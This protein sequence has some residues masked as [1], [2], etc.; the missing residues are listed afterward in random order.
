VRRWPAIVVLSALLFAGCGLV[1]RT[2]PPSGPA[3]FP[4]LDAQLAAVGIH[5]ERVVSGDAGCED[6]TLIP[7]AIG[8]DASGLDQASPVRIHLF[9]FRNRD[10]FERRR[11]DV[12]SCAAAFVTDPDTFE[13][14]EDSPYVAAG[15]GPWA[16]GFEAALRTGLAAAAGTGG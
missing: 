3:D 1:S 4:A 8:F 6:P 13:Q 10:A 16:P 15:Q 9:I 7:T 2:P 14:I 12:P 5:V 11:A